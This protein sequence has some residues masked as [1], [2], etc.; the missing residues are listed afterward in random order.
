LRGGGV[1]VFAF[2]LPVIGWFFVMPLTLA[3]GVGAALRAW[4]EARR[5]SKLAS[6]MQT[7][8]AAG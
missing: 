3:S 1:L 4:S 2:L 7:K 5:E 8:A 6:S